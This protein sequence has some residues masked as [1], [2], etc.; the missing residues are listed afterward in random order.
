MAGFNFSFNL[1]PP[2]VPLSL[3][4]TLGKGGAR[5]ISITSG[6]GYAGSIYTSDRAGQ[7]T[8]DG[9]A[10]SGET[11]LTYTMSLANEGKA[12]QCANSNTIEMWVP[13]DASGLTALMDVRKGLTLS[14]SALA[15]W[16]SQAGGSL[17]QSTGSLQ[18]VYGETAFAGA[19]G[20][21][22]TSGQGLGGLSVGVAPSSRT[23]ISL[24]NITS[25]GSDSA[26]WKASATGG[27][28]YRLNSTPRFDLVSVGVAVRA[29]AATVFP[30]STPSVAS[31]R[32]TG[33]GPFSFR[34]A[35]VETNAGTSSGGFSGTGTMSIGT[36][37]FGGV[38]SHQILYDSYLSD[39]DTAKAEAW[40][41]WTLGLSS[42][43]GATHP[44]K[45]AAPRNQ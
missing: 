41:V 33:S 38:M 21:T 22:L 23:A 6:G 32:I 14:G 25:G 24:L 26:V 11:G 43:L 36:G 34:R 35:G 12:I 20:I 7:W 4:N 1:L 31:S 13:S 8:A 30:T 16:A 37:T 40:A 27:Y 45:S 17:T 3:T 42:L 10:I 15:A 18:P 19:P 2:N 5:T 28:E 39:S 29:N 9:V 44:Y